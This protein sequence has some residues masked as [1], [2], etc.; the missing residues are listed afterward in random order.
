MYA[1]RSYYGHGDTVSD[2]YTIS[3]QSLH[4]NGQNDVG[5]QVG[6]YTPATQ[7][8]DN[9]YCHSDGAGGAPNRA[10]AWSDTQATGCIV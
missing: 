8:C 10:V 9:L 6:S 1:I 2:S 7:A 3:N 4:I 5:L